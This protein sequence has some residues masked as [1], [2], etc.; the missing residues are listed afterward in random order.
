TPPGCS[1]R[2]ASRQIGRTSGTK[3]FE[4]GWKTRPNRP[5]AKVERSAMSPSTVSTSSPSRAATRRSWRSWAGELAGPG[6]SA[7]AAARAGGG[8]GL[9]SAGRQAG[10]LGSRQGGDPVA[11]HG[12]GGGEDDPPVAPPGGGDDLGADRHRPAVALLHLPV[13]GVAVVVADVH[14]AAPGG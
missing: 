12:P 4:H 8:G 7:P 5:S 13:P 2:N 9:G 14:S 11:G 6:T 1:T 3:Q 10:D